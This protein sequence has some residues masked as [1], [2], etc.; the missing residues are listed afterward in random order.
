MTKIMWRFSKKKKKMEDGH[1]KPSSQIFDRKKCQREFYTSLLGSKDA[2]KW[3]GFNDLNG[4][5]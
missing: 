1:K 2:E 4:K 5:Q 3:N